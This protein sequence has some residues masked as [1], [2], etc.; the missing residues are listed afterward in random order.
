[1]N[2]ISDAKDEGKKSVI[3]YKNIDENSPLIDEHIK[4]VL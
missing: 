3:L 1:M 2:N 4:I